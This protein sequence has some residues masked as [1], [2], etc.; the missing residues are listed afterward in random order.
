MI[1]TKPRDNQKVVALSEFRFSTLHK[2][3][4][5]IYAEL[6]RNAQET[7]E[8]KRSIIKQAIPRFF[9]RMREYRKIALAEIAKRFSISLTRLESFEQGGVGAYS[10]IIA[11]YNYS[12]GGLH[13]FE[14]FEQ[15]LREFREPKIKESKKDCAQAVFTQ[16]GIKI[17]GVDYQNF[18]VRRGVVLEM[19][20]RKS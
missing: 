16:F 11:A 10:D 18:D 7:D 9:K 3:M 1:N 17:P 14:C 2:Y 15:A 6:D 12:C 20:R 5:P 4:S 8:K 19:R 13:E